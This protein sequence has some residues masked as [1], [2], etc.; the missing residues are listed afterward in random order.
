MSLTM[1]FGRNT[2]SVA[3]YKEASLMFCLARDHS[4]LGASGTPTP[5]IYDGGRLVAH[6]SYNGKVWPGSPR[7]WHEDLV[8]LFVPS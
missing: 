8:P 1:K 2:C 5:L 4:G 6:V 3:S 7:G